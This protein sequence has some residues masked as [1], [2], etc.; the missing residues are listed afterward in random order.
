M[1]RATVFRTQAIP[2]GLPPEL[3]LL[4]LP[5]GPIFARRGS[6]AS[7]LTFTSLTNS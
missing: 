1:A 6:H 2:E 4:K 7:E 5:I 3:A